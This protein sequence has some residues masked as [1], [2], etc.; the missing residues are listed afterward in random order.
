MNL[1]ELKGLAERNA[2]AMHS[3]KFVDG[4]ESTTY[5]F[6]Q[7]KTLTDAYEVFR[8]FVMPTLRRHGHDVA[9]LGDINIDLFFSNV[10]TRIPLFQSR[11]FTVC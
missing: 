2:W 1:P 8:V 11:H 6:A 4:C 9:G 7:S 3:I 5:N 10:K